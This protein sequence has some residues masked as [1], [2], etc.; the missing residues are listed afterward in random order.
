MMK[1]KNKPFAILTVLS[2][3]VS[4]VWIVSAGY[5]GFFDQETDTFRETYTVEN[6]TDLRVKGKNGDVSIVVWA[7]ETIEVFAKKRTYFGQEELDK[8][9][10][11]VS[12]GTDFLV[13]ADYLHRFVW[14]SVDFEIKIPKNVTVSEVKTTNGAITLTG[15]RGTLSAKTSHGDISI[16]DHIGDI[17]LD[18]SNGDISV[19]NHTGD[20]SM[21]SS[22]GELYAEGIR[23]NVVGETSNG[24]IIYKYV[25]GTVTAETSNGRI[26]VDDTKI[27]RKLTTSNGGIT[28]VFHNLSSSGT[29][30]KTSNSYVNVRIPDDMDANLD[31]ETS[32]GD[33]KTQITI[34][35]SSNSGDEL[36]GTLGKGGPRLSIKTSNGDVELTGVDYSDIVMNPWEVVN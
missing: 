16:R 12:N 29:V 8:V 15:T 13:E 33:I 36:T 28:A 6:G 9:E 25:N 17:T 18:S 20:I 24:K 32:N 31:V 11:K 26:S 14:V 10:I 22:N 4:I 5:L 27:V 1:E 30:I 35:I 34:A 7:E 3:L 23:G 2:I 19:R 21:D